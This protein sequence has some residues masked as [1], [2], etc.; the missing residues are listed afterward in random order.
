MGAFLL[1]SSRSP[2][3]RLTRKRLLRVLP[4]MKVN[5]VASRLF[6]RRYTLANALEHSSILIYT[7]SRR[8]F[9]HLQRLRTG[10]APR[11]A[12]KRRRKGFG[13]VR[14]DRASSGRLG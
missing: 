7:L 13:G 5:A 12:G 8:I 4:Q 10:P 2:R 11:R 9:I 6:V 14:R 3:F 1:L